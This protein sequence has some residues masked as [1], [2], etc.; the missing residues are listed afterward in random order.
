M[1]TTV[2][3]EKFG[4]YMYMYTCVHPAKTYQS[5]GIGYHTK[6]T[7]NQVQMASCFPTVDQDSTEILFISPRLLIKRERK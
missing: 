7:Q 3:M 6:G 4:M 1:G 5:M 2:Y